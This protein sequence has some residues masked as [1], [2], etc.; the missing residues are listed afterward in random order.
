MAILFFAIGIMVFIASS[1]DNLEKIEKAGSNEHA[2]K[3]INYLTYK[4]NEYEVKEHL[5]TLLVIGTDNFESEDYKESA[6]YNF[7]QADFFILFVFDNDLKTITPI[8]INRDT[9]CKVY[10]LTV[11]GDVGGTTYEQIALAHTYGSGKED[12]C[13]NCVRT[14]SKLAF[15]APID[16]YIAF[17]MDAV[18]TITD[19]VGGV[20]IDGDTISGEQ[21]LSYVRARYALGEK[22]NE[23]RLARHREFLNAFELSARQAIAEDNAFSQEAINKLMPYLTTNLSTNDMADYIDKLEEYELNEVNFA[24]GKSIISKETGFAEFYLDKKS[25]WQIVKSTYC[26]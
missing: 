18:P 9:M 21:A 7:E 22:N 15:N 1:V 11:T 4:N 8:Q 26:N 3:Q 20:T 10:W 14:V 6:F 23:K 17:T 25:F 5:D 12:S 19:L 2:E 13:K 24:N 16:D